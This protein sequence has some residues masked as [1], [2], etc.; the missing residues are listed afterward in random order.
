MT[1]RRLDP[2]KQISFV[3]LTLGGEKVHA[4]TVSLFRDKK[5]QVFSL[6]GSLPFSQLHTMTKPMV[7]QFY[8]HSSESR[9][10][11]SQG[12]LNW[13]KHQRGNMNLALLTASSVQSTY[14]PELQKITGL[15]FKTC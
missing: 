9:E 12:T 6:P 13:R 8:S 5:V 2:N 7:W 14:S 11:R 10:T 4:M 1:V 15:L 3:Q